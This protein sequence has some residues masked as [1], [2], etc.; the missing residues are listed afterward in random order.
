MTGTTAPK[1]LTTRAQGVATIMLNRAASLNALD[2]DLRLSLLAELQQLEAADDVGVIVLTGNGRGFCVGQDLSQAGELENCHDTVARTYNPLIAAIVRSDKPY[3]AA[4]NGAA[5]GAGMGLALACDLVVMSEA[6]SMACA[7]GKM[8]LV[9][10]SGV[11]AHLVQ[12]TGYRRAFELATSGRKITAQEAER[13]G[14]ATHVVP[15]DE[16]MN[17][18]QA[19]AVAVAQEPAKTLALTK[20]Q[21]RASTEVPFSVSLEQEALS[22]GVAGATPEHAARRAAFLS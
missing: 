15:V 3:I 20:R 18:V 1:F 13:Y 14:L 8:A 19:L 12:A 6:A 22:Q 11:S 10:D 2:E 16:L 17:A 9:P 7:F 4:V 5:V 21:L